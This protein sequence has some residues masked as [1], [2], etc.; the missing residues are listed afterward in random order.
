MKNRIRERREELKLNQGEL[1]KKVGISR[2]QINRIEN[3]KTKNPGIEI[4]K[5]IA[6]A[7]YVDVD[8]LWCDR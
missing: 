6:K 2:E 5:K 1:A 4:C 3:E 7:L 8:K